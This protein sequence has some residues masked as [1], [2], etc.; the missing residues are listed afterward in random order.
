MSQKTEIERRD[1]ESHPSAEDGLDT[2]EGPSEKG[3]REAEEEAEEN[4]SESIVKLMESNSDSDI[5]C[6]KV[7]IQ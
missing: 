6:S 7:A 3:E 5:E 1:P 2:R 4:E